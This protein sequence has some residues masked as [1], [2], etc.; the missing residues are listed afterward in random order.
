MNGQHTMAVRVLARLLAAVAV[1]LAGAAVPGWPAA[2]GMTTGFRPPGARNASAAGAARPAGSWGRA[3]PVP[4]LSALNT[5]GSAYLG[6]VSCASAGNCA[7]GGSY[8]DRH[9]RYHAFVAVERK[10][11]WGTAIE[12][13]GLA[14]LST[15]DAEV[16]SVSCGPAGN[17][18][19]GG[20]YTAR[21]RELGF[22]A[23]E[24]N[25]RWSRAIEVTGPAARSKGGGTEV[26]S[27]SCNGPA[28]DCVAGG[29]YPVADGHSQGF[30]AVERNGRWNRAIK[31]PGL[32]A[33][34]KGTSASVVS[35]SCASAGSCAAGGAY[36]D[37]HGHARG[38]VVSERRGRWGTAIEVPGLA[39]LSEGG[40]AF[41]ASVSCA[42]A[43]YCAAGG[44][45]ADQGFV[46]VERHGVWGTAI[47]VPGLGTLNTG[48]DAEVNSVSCASAGNCAAGGDYLSA[49]ANGFQGFV[50]L[51]RDG[52]WGT[53][54][55]VP[56]LAALNRADAPVI[57][58]SCA[59]AGTCAS[60]GFYTDADGRSH[61]FLALARDGAW[62]RAVQVP[63]LA[64]LNKGRNAQVSSVSCASAGGCAAGGSYTDRHHHFQAFVVNQTG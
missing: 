14:V 44:P 27:V 5:G 10:G 51:E 64:A 45:Y 22:V 18:A 60:G 20:Y 28:G 41:V 11:R 59:P 13:P 6:S 46:A 25:G 32:G 15:G 47:E 7:A 33:L 2:A 38:F 40:N 9:D 52:V 4:G 1:A 29:Y 61:A 49:S 56:G 16:N 50:A 8:T 12:V 31:V 63:G 17:C 42:P 37:G 23:V 21:H 62:G 55:E 54:I 58:V 30:L 57:S 34:N 26:Q 35:V 19:A 39:A 53:A 3:I 36:R 48:L 43:G 24:R